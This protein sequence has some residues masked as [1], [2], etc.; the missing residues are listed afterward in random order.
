MNK[1]IMMALLFS[2]LST[3]N[4]QAAPRVKKYGVYT[5]KVI[6]NSDPQNKHRVKVKFP[7]VRDND[8]GVWSKVSRG[9]NNERGA[10]FL[11]EVGD[12]VIVSFIAGNPL[13]PVVLGILWNGEDRPATR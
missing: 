8:K 4:I 2:F 12:E 3:Q 6:N 9:S 1:I 5:G 7:W 13:N 10:F 11:P